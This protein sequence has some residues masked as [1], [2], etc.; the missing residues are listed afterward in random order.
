MKKAVTS[1]ILVLVF[2]AGTTMA[3]A[4]FG[5]LADKAKNAVS[6]SSSS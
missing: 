1:S 5:S 3:S 2:A 4:Q 6:G